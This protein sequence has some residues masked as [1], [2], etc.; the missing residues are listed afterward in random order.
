MPS[1]GRLPRRAFLTAA[2]AG[3]GGVVA[4]SWRSGGRT[5]PPDERSLVLVDLAGG[6]DGLGTVVPAGDER[7]RRLRGRL[8]LDRAEVRRLA[9][10]VGLHPALPRLADRFAA[11][12]LAIVE[13]VGSTPAPR[14]HEE[15]A[16]AADAVEVDPVRTGW[17]G[18]LADGG[19]GPGRAP[20]LVSL[21]AEP[22]PAFAAR[23][24]VSAALGVVPERRASFAEALDRVA[25]RIAARAAARVHHVRL[26][27]FDTHAQQAHR[28][29]RLLAELDR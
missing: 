20:A 5:A 6:N 23:G 28:H 22:P 3:V 8:A 19:L 24:G 16:D 1:P 10:G 7:Y 15:A 4:A 27:G 21:G 11:G 17:L 12:G 2:A 18:R 14:T 26:P 9:P 29:A 13:G 25:D